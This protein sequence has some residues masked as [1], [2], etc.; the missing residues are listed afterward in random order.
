VNVVVDIGHSLREGFFMFW[1]TLWALV[2]GFGLSGAVQAFVSRDEMHRVMGDHSP[3]SVVRASALGM[4]SSSCSYAASA[5]AKSLFQKGADFISAMVFMFASTNLVVELGIVLIILLGWRFAVA[6]FIGGPLMI[7]LLT[8]AGGMLLNKGAIES[9]RARLHSEQATDHDHGP[10]QDAGLQQLP[11][12]IRLR[13]MAGWSDAAGYT[14]G[15]LRMLRKELVIGYVVAG[16]LAVLVPASVWNA[17]FL[18]GHGFWTTLENVIVGP[19]IAFISF[20]CSIGNVPMAAALWHGG[21]SFGGVISFI[22]ADLVALPLVLIYR[23]FYGTKLTVQLVALFWGVMSAAGLAVEG[24]FHATGEIPA[25]RPAQIVHTG[26]QWNYTTVLNILFL[27]VFGVLLWLNHDRARF[28]AGR[29]Y[30]TDPVCGMQVETA[31]SPARASSGGREYF[32]CSDQCRDRFQADPSEYLG[33]CPPPI[34]RCQ[35]H[36]A[37]SDGDRRLEAPRARGPGS[38]RYP[39]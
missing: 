6:E 9:A 11:W 12:R 35:P 39:V 18:H 7:V 4:A 22:F 24:I 27:G 15:D 26:F 30:A 1:E 34:R 14:M 20:V 25:S 10:E 3:R 23:K 37:V 16:F 17:V 13:S 29:G 32:F 28:G 5:M 38:G 21:I 8:L 33:M 19:I 36:I 2:L 31:T